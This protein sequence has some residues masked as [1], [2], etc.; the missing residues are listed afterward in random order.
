MGWHKESGS[1]GGRANKAARA[2]AFAT[3]RQVVADSTAQCMHECTSSALA[4]AITHRA[5]FF[6]N[7]TTLQGS[8]LAASAAACT[9]PS[10]LETPVSPVW[11]WI[12]WPER[13]QRRIARR[14]RLSLAGSARRSKRGAFAEVGCHTGRGCVKQAC[15]VSCCCRRHAC[16]PMPLRAGHPPPRRPPPLLLTAACLSSGVQA[17]ATR[18]QA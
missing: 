11:A 1:E 17:P 6:S 13:P 18:S 5:C 15:W 14:R 8:V 7:R 10:S 2:K 4:R 12:T 16:S 3:D 9:P